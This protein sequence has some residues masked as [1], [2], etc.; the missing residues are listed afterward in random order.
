LIFPAEGLKVRLCDDMDLT[1][2]ELQFMT[3]LWDADTPLT[4][5]EVLRRSV[6]KTWADASL[7]TILNKLLEK[8]AIR[9]YGFEKDG[10]AISRTFVPVLSCGEYYGNLFS[11]HMKKDIPVIFSALMNR[12]DIDKNTLNTLKQMIIERKAET[13]K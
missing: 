7:H 9:E 12:E 1:K 6:D 13:D 4:A 11:G 3:V 10:K 5:S 2:N 8:G